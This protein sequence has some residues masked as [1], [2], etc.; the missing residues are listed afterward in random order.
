MHT[1]LPFKKYLMTSK[2]LQYNFKENKIFNYIW[3]VTFINSRISILIIADCP[4]CLEQCQTLECMLSMFAKWSN[5]LI[6]GM[7]PL[8]DTHKYTQN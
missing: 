7:L 2:T 6:C 4:Q 8:K 1:W 3:T 5:E